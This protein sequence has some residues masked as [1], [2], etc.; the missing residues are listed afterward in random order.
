MAMNHAAPEAKSASW[1]SSQTSD[2]PRS[3]PSMTASRTRVSRPP[4]LS[5]VSAAI[6]TRATPAGVNGAERCG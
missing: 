4:M 6:S 2:G 1:A 3:V 5:V